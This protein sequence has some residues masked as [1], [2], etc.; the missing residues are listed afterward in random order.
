MA[1]TDISNLVNTSRP[2]LPQIYAYTTPEIARELDRQL[3]LNETVLRT[4]LLRPE[5]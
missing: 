4:K 3:G 5:A 2:A 1:F